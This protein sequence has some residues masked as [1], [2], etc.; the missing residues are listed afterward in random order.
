MRM[1]AVTEKIML[2]GVIVASPGWLACA[3][4]NCAHV[5]LEEWMTRRVPSFSTVAAT[6]FHATEFHTV[7]R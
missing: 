5:L 1:P 3:G 6:E 7:P 4:E 2:D